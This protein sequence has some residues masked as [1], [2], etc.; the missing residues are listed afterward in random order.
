M[1]EQQERRDFPGRVLLQYSLSISVLLFIVTAG[2]AMA[3]YPG[4]TK[5]Q[6]KAVG[7]Q[8][9]H[10]YLCDV[11][12]PTALNGQPN[13]FASILMMIAFAAVYYGFLVMLWVTTPSVFI[14]RGWLR[15]I[16]QS[17]ALLSIFG[18][19][20]MFVDGMGWLHM[21]HELTVVLTAIPGIIATGII[22]VTLTRSWVG[23]HSLALLA[24]VALTTSV[25]DTILYVRV[26]YFGVMETPLVPFM[27]R[28]AVISLLA[29]FLQLSYEFRK[30]GQTL[31]DK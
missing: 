2:T 7:H 4:G 28:L 26:S 15:R 30:I 6:L 5:F 3:Y 9:W 21:T 10:N 1:S 29:W 12:T 23:T 13:T 24:L 25:A 16:V 17:L 8:F 27:Q 20:M 19:F 14:E 31:R 22:I 18:T 11:M